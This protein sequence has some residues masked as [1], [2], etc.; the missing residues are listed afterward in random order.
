MSEDEKKESKK[1]D[2]DDTEEDSAPADDAADDAEAADDEA[3]D[4]EAADDDA[5]DDEAA[6]DDAAEA[7]GGHHGHDHKAHVRGY[8][9]VFV[10]LIVLTV[11]EVGVAHPSL[12]IA[13]NLLVTGLVALA[14]GKAA[15]VALYYMH[16]KGETKF[17]K[18]TVVFPVAFPA[19]YA[20]IL[21]AE[22]M[23]RALWSQG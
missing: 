10:V 23:Y 4:D 19:L 3:A 8:M 16:L 18:W 5:A 9:R 20:F 2:V 15:I 17:M 11:L 6:D 14:L 21:I 1:D 13:K 22:G 7:H 12:G